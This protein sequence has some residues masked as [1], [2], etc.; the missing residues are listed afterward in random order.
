[1]TK[2]T[3]YVNLD[4]SSYSEWKSDVLS[5][6]YDCDNNHSS[7]S[8]DLASEFWYNV[9]FP[10]GYPVMNNRLDYTIWDN[11]VENA[12]DKFDLIT[13]K[14]DI[15]QG[16]IIVFNAWMGSEVGHIGF[17]ET[18]YLGN[19]NINILSQANGA[20]YTSIDHYDL[21]YFL[22]A[23]R[24]KAWHETPPTPPEPPVPEPVN[25]HRFKWALYCD[26]L[27]RKRNGL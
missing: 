11:R 3:G 14:T 16:D 5:N 18:D 10:Q 26:K 13:S 20:I 12:G 21:T 1:M 9:G 15:L 7:A 8:W 4:T 24:Y 25:K 19:T 23:F 27:R 2:Y 6:E 17:A 22:G